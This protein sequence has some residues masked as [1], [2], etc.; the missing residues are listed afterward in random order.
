MLKKCFKFSFTFLLAVILLLTGLGYLQYRQVTKEMSIEAKIE[1]IKQRDHYHELAKIAP[2]LVHATVAI[3]DKRFYEH[4]GIDPIALVRV[5]RDSLQAGMIVGGGSTITQQLAKN[6]YFDYQP[7][8]VRKFAELFVVFDLERE[9]DKDTILACYLN[10]INY[11]DNHFGIYEAATGYYGVDPIDL[12]LDQATILAGIPQ[13]PSNLQLSNGSEYTKLKQ[14][15]VLSA[16]LR[17]GMISE[18][19]Y[20]IIL[21]N[22]Q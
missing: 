11:G 6:L 10:I 12:T 1:D 21:S 18:N 5:A 8:L 20:Q 22:Q 9:F 4:G 3:E 16:M 14:K 2:N 7:S 15:A 13:S 17:E 19:E